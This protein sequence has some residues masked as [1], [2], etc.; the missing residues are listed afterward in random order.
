VVER[1]KRHKVPVIGVVGSVEGA[2]ELFVNDAL[3]ADLESLVDERTSS[4]DAMQ[5]A[6]SRLS[7]KTKVLIQRYLSRNYTYEAKF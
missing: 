6:A 5:N 7:T 2:R 4:D 1:A 3:L